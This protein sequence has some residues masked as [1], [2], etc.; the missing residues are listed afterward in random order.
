MPS[1]APATARCWSPSTRV[2][3]WSG[4]SGIGRRLVE[5]CIARARA[6]GR[7]GISILSTPAMTAAHA[8]YRDLGFVREPERDLELPEVTLL[9]FRL[10][11]RP[12]VDDR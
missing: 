12:P 10:P 7:F 11:L 1:G 5:A 6:D 8:L 3:A 4:R 2:A 9:A